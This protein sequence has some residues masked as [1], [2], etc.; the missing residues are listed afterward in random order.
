M[1]SWSDRH[2]GR[3]RGVEIPLTLRR[4][5]LDRLRVII[6]RDNIMQIR[7]AKVRYPPLL[8]GNENRRLL[9]AACFENQ[10][11]TT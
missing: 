1:T 6:H 11:L 4:T 9:P 7:S 5:Q 8:G 10:S 2:L 3:C